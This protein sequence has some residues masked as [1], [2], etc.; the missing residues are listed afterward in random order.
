MQIVRGP[1]G[2]IYFVENGTRVRR[3]DPQGIITTIAGTGV[4]GDAGDGGPA[5]T[6]TFCQT[7]F[8]M[9]PITVGPDG[10]IY[11]VSENVGR[12]GS[13][14]R[15]IGPD[16]NIYH[17]AGVLNGDCGYGS[18]FGNA[19]DENVPAINTPM[20]RTLRALAVMPDGSILIGDSHNAVV[21]R[22]S[23]GGIR[24]RFAGVTQNMGDTGDGGPARL[25]NL[26]GPELI[27]AAPD[28]SVYIGTGNGRTIRKVSPA[29]IITRVVGTGGSCF[30]RTCPSVLNMPALQ[31]PFS[32]LKG[33]DVSS[34]NVLHFTDGQFRVAMRVTKPLPGFDGA[35]IGVASEDGGELYRFDASGRHLTTLDPMTGVTH[36]RFAYDPTGQLASVTD[37]SGNITSIVRAADGTVQEMVGPYGQ[38]TR[39]A[40][41]AAGYLASAR[42]PGG[43]TVRFTYA[44]TGLMASRTDAGGGVHAYA[45]DAAGLLVSDR[46]ADGLVQTLAAA[47]TTSGKQV[48]VSKGSTETRTYL[49]ESVVTGGYRRVTT[50]A[51]GLAITTVVGAADTTT[52]Q[53]PDGTAV[54][55]VSRADSRFGMQSPVTTT[56]VRLP[57][58]IFRTTRNVRVVTLAT[59]GDPLSLRTQTDTLVENGIA[60]TATFDAVA[61]TLTARSAGGRSSVSVL[62]SLGR[63]V[64]TA[65]GG[66]AATQTVYDARGRVQQTIDAG[67]VTAL[68]YDASGR[69]EAVTDPLGQVT[70]LTTDS[71]GR[72]V[73]LQDAAG[74]VGFAYDSAGNLSA[75][76]PAGRPAHTFTYTLGGLPSTYD[77][78]AVPGVSST[79]TRYRY[80]ADLRLRS[81]V[82]PTGDSIA[83]SY[84][85]AG[86]PTSVTHAD[87]T[88]S[89]AYNGVT[90][91]LSSV[92]SS[93]S[94]SYA[95]TYDGALL[96]RSTLAGGV[97]SGTIAYGH[98]AFFRP[99]SVAVNGSAVTLGYDADGLLTSAGAFTLARSTT[100]AL[101]STASV[102]GV[103]TS[104]AYDSTGALASET[105]TAN[106]NALYTYTLTRDV[107]DRI[108]RNVETVGGI[109]TDTRFAYDSTGRLSEVMRDGVPYASYQYD[110]N[111]NRTRRTSSAG[112]EAG[113]MD[114]QD[115]L[116]SYGGTTYQYTD[117]GELRLAITGPDTTRY[118]YDAL[119]ALR[120]VTLPGGARIDYVIDAT[121]RRIGRKVNGV[122]AQGFLYESELRIA[123]EL[124]PSGA[125]LS[126]FVYGTQANVPEYMV[127]GGTRYRIITDHLGSVRLVVDAATGAIQQRL[128]YDEYGRIT[129]NTNPGF[130]PFGYVGGILDDATGLMRFGA[131]DYDARAGRW[132][133]RDPIGLRGGALNLYEYVSGAPLNLT[134]RTGQCADQD[135]Q[136]KQCRSGSMSS[137]PYEYWNNQKLRRQTERLFNQSDK[138][139][140]ERAAYL[141]RNRDGGVSLGP[142]A[143]GA[144]WAGTVNVGVPPRG[145]IGE[146]HTHPRLSPGGREPGGRPSD[147]D[148][149][150]S[151]FYGVPGFVIDRDGFYAYGCDPNT[152][153]LKI[154]R[155]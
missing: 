28:G 105:T 64:R 31:I 110:A 87:D 50:N 97:V 5:A 106:G 62:D 60:S 101:P 10:S 118:H 46:N 94:G 88:T 116:T 20:S 108:V 84:D 57:S 133:T 54:T 140:R 111:G 72:T 58:G 36:V 33:L 92:G 136:D 130:Q 109:T 43:E 151:I 11:V 134:D 2:R 79:T 22:V 122:L 42:A 82:R 40:L 126:R 103:A 131:R 135:E 120:W 34:D 45:Y 89:F 148:M 132:T 25:A 93:T 117:A 102:D 141:F 83:T 74:T 95:L 71:L 8:R 124:T 19:C 73:A 125:V 127:R 152:P 85:A 138:D 81:I 21:W 23:P 70:R 51:A 137:D 128:D 37:A 119:S 13:R 12:L 115:R 77:A 144:P 129:T 61:R 107:L 155:P 15:R 98:D 114:A 3:I 68:A 53:R 146:M 69:L 66:L 104:Y 75:L 24:T 147:W 17:F 49:T 35:D 154:P 139:G 9:Q 56:T 142:I 18:W 59:P 112:I 16:G 6:A 47:S 123:A 32:Q 149:Y 41:D 78:P 14:V 55:S 48:T 80:D 39:F 29:G 27:A 7:T 30:A 44:A 76:T 113:V 121:A 4:C 65:S 38:R 143:V 91:L 90:G 99:T 67:R 86:R 96:K 1:D 26:A 100:N 150:R 52:V 63:V 145:A 153:I